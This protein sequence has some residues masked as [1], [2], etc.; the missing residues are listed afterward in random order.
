MHLTGNPQAG[1]FV[2]QIDDNGIGM[3][4]KTLTEDLVDFGKSFWK[5]ARASQE[6]S[7]IQASGLSP[8]GR[9]GIGFFSVFMI[10][11][12][13]KVFSRRFDKGLDTV[14]CLSFTNGL[15]LRPTLSK[16][17]P[18]KFGMDVSTRVELEFRNRHLP[19]PNNIHIHANIQG[20][21]GF[22]VEFHDY[23]ASL[24]SGIG[25]RVFVEWN[26]SV[27]QVHGGFPPQ[28]NDR[29]KW[30]KTLSY[31][32][33][34]ANTNAQQIVAAHAHRLREIRDGDRIYG[35]AAIN[36]GLSMG[37]NFVSARAVGGLVPLHNRGDE[38]FV[39]LIDHYPRNAKRE[40]GE[41]TASASVMRYWLEE[42]LEL[43]RG[44]NLNVIQSILASYSL[45][46][47]DFDP[48]EIFRGMLVIRERGVGY[49]NLDQLEPF[50]DG[51]NRL[52][53]R[54]STFGSYLD[55]YGHQITIPS[56]VTCRVIEGGKFN[57]VKMENGVP[58]NPN[59][60]IGVV[61]RI[62]EGKGR[63]P[64][65]R[66]TAG[67]YSGPFGRCDCLEVRI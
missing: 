67:A 50:L 15:S 24:V 27:T 60:L 51:G 63:S 2:L 16:H 14:R 41:K 62:L 23:V 42:Q 33:S 56:V 34:G 35:L 38:A 21:E 40:A 30:L 57:D 52:G 22:R 20:Y 55:N 58:K 7:G 18:E 46:E 47:F 53:F 11:D 64:T 17:R 9:F 49:L 1:R 13:V 59:S 44:E 66:T 19:D 28:T 4:E 29:E 5:S 31:V 25:A 37:C 36:T 6:F 43:I 32:S 61:Q 39:G 48:I 10:A 65:W 45:S 3:S 54:V 26:G 12:S 8:A